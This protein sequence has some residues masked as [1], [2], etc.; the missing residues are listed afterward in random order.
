MKLIANKKG[1]IVF[2][3]TDLPG[4]KQA[5]EVFKRTYPNRITSKFHGVDPRVVVFEIGNI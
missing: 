4:V 3:D 5:I 1:V 2:D